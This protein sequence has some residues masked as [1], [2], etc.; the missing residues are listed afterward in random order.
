MA[1][2]I[3]VPLANVYSIRYNIVP[4]ASQTFQAA[5]TY[6]VPI[7]TLFTDT[8]NF[9]GLNLQTTFLLNGL[10]YQ[11]TSDQN[12]NYFFQVP[13]DA[14]I[15]SDVNIS[16]TLNNCEWIQIEVITVTI[17]IYPETATQTKTLY[18][19]YRE[20]NISNRFIETGPSVSS[21]TILFYQQTSGVWFLGLNTSSN[22]TSIYYYPDRSQGSSPSNHDYL[23]LNQNSIPNTL[24]VDKFYS[25]IL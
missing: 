16:F 10:K 12:V 22:S 8:V 18:N 4:I 9:T 2:Y 24:Q 17:F 14:K 15:V 11:T 20:V 3:L 23:S 19:E 13:N 25:R 7:N 1:I 5:T 21:P 6:S